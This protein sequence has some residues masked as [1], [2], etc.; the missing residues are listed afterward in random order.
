MHPFIWW[1]QKEMIIFAPAKDSLIVLNVS[2]NQ[3]SQMQIFGQKFID[4]EMLTDQKT[5]LIV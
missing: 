1:F 3:L 5:T 2:I 4:I